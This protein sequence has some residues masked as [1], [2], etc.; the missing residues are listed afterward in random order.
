MKKFIIPYPGLRPFTE[1]ESIFFK[2]RDNHIKQIITQLQDKKIVIVTGASGAGKSS[3]IFAGVVPNARAGFFKATFNSWRVVSFRPERSPLHNLSRE[4]ALNLDLDYKDVFNELKYGF[5][6]LVNI[7]KNSKYYIDP[8]SKQWKNADEQTLKKLKSQGSNLLIIADQFEEFFTNPENFAGNHPSIEAYT[9]VNLLLE[10]ASIALEENL[11]IF[12]IVTM[13]SDFISDCVAFKGL[14]EYIGFSQ[15]FVP[16]LKRNEL[17]QVIEEPAKLAGGKVSKR[18]VEVLINEIRESSDPLPILQHTLHQLWLTAN[19]GQDELDLIHLAKNAGLHTSYLN[20]QDKQIFNAWFE[21]LNENEKKYFEKPSVSNVLNYHA[22][23][24]YDNAY[25]YFLE[26]TPWIEDKTV[27]SEEDAH[28][29]IKTTFIGLTRIDEGRAVRNRITLKEITNLVN[30]PGITY[31]V[32]NGVINIFREPG[33]T[34]IR[35]FIDPDFPDTRY[36]PA[37]TVLDITHEALIR[38][39]QLLQQW[40]REEEENVND[41]LEFKVQLKRWLDSGKK[42]EYLLPL[43]PLTYFEK[44]YQRCKPNEYWIA[45]YD[46]STL[47]NQ[48]KIEQARYLA[49]NI[50]LYLETSRNYII[51]Q[52]KR[53]KALR[54][55]LSIATVIIISVLIGF[56]MWALKEKRNADL[57]R[58][59]AERQKNEAIKANLKAEKEK[60]RAE[61]EK[62]RAEI[63]AKKALIAKRQSDSAKNVALRMMKIAEQ[64]RIIAQREALRALMEKKKAD[65][66]RKIAEIQKQKA[67]RASKEAQRL[68]LLSLAQSLAFKATQRY[69]DEQVNLLLAYYAYMLNKQNGGKPYEPA[70]YQ[71]LRYAY[72]LVKN[73]EPIQL[74]SDKSPVSGFFL[75]DQLTVFYQVS[76]GKIYYYDLFENK[77]KTI[78]FKHKYLPKVAILKSHFL[79]DTFLVAYD[80]SGKWTLF[81][82]QQHNSLYFHKSKRPASIASQNDKLFILYP[83]KVEVWQISNNQANLLKTKQLIGKR[84]AVLITDKN[85][86]N[87]VY[88]ITRRGKIL[89]FNLKDNK[90]TKTYSAN[91]SNNIVTAAALSPDS[92][93]IAIGLANGS[94]NLID[95]QT[96]KLKDKISV[97]SAMVKAVKF[98]EHNTKLISVSPDNTINIFELDNLH[99]KPITINISNKKI[100]D[101]KILA[102]KIFTLYDNNTFLSYY[103]EPEVYAQKVKSLIKRN[104][105]DA[106]WK[107]FF[108]NVIPKYDILK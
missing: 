90:I 99:D 28:Y 74:A 62:L 42:K 54:R 9:T 36:I 50:K 26:N 81:N 27:I 31:E 69:D 24:L 75:P 38:N 87:H 92:K 52:E 29:I 17:Q 58:Q 44:W 3:L 77:R 104:F 47:S 11:P 18:L 56:T 35:P 72:F 78:K 85:N 93:Q 23:R 108:G 55:I 59:I 30:K 20:Q 79:N 48:E 43:G 76:T 66:L 6:A 2:G 41:F 97:V 91:I 57:Q 14:P 21:K 95:T 53:K 5:S 8:E 100:K 45:K 13:R 32:V 63:E 103:L 84:G 40:E 70:I 34:F 107:L 51:A 80:I 102:N 73:I 89:V 46:K 12:I 49:E 86:Q 25:L 4:L 60:Q 1:E 106:E 19:N 37:D 105:T 15:F 7:Y 33:S 61:Q 22:N 98:D 96:W 82:L 83:N 68:T 10:T 71:G 67:I 16:R 94:I 39:W 65:S 101:I 88:I 64:Q